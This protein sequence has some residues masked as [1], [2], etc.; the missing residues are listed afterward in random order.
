MIQEQDDTESSTLGSQ[1]SSAETNT[2]PSLSPIAQEA[3]RELLHNL[4]QGHSPKD[5]SPET[6]TDQLL[7]RLSYKDFPGLQCAHT[8]L[9]LKSKEKILDI[10]FQS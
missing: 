4:W 2:S 1:V 8:K 3:V 9:T 6:S 10:F 5:N 7:N